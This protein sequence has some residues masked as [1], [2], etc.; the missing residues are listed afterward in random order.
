MNQKQS[1]HHESAVSV[2]LALGG[3]AV[4]G[5]QRMLVFCVLQMSWVLR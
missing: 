2:G 3:G 4:L 1:M 5:A